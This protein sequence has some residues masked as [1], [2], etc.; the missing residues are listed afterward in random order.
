MFLTFMKTCRGLL[1]IS[2]LLAANLSWAAPAGQVEFAQGLASAQ[3]SGRAPRFLNKG[4]VL[5]EGDEVNVVVLSID[6][7]GKIRLSRKRAIGKEP[8]EKITLS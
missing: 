6:R 1:V 2:L 7:E 8:G 5:Q 4:D 3:Q